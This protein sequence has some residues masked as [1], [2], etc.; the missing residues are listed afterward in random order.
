M[1]EQ[2]FQIDLRHELLHLPYFLKQGMSVHELVQDHT[3]T[4]MQAEV[5]DVLVEKLPD[6][7]ENLAVIPKLFNGRYTLTNKQNGEER[8]IM[9]AT[10][11]DDADFAPGQRIVCDRAGTDFGFAEDKIVVWTKKRGIGEKRSPY[12]KYANLI[13]HLFCGHEPD[14]SLEDNVAEDYAVVCEKRCIVC[15]RILDKPWSLHNGS[16]AICANMY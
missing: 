9:I 10:Q 11:A 12:D 7:E 6:P 14:P 15:N 13:N 8:T 4:R 2:V 16:G 5:R 1:T 3:W